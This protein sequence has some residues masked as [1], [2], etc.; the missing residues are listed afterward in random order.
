MVRVVKAALRKKGRGNIRLGNPP[1][2]RRQ[3]SSRRHQETPKPCKSDS[4][5]KPYPSEATLRSI[6]PIWLFGRVP[7]GFWQDETNRRNYLLWLGYKLGFR[8]IEDWYRITH[9]DLKRHNGQGLAGLYWNASAIVG[10][11]ECFPEYDWK[12]WLFK[13]APRAFWHDK[14]NHRRYMTW[15]GQQLGYR[16]PEDWY[17]VATRDFQKHKGGSFL[18]EYHGFVSAVM[19]YLPDYDWKEWMFNQAPSGFWAS[20]KNRHRYMKWLGKRL[21]YKRWED[22]Y[23]VTENDFR[24]NYGYECFK[25]YGGSVIAAVK[26]LYPTRA[27]CEWRFV[28]VP[29]G[30]WH[31]QEN[32][33]RYVR[34]LGEQLG[35]RRLEDWYQV[36]VKD[37]HN[38]SGGAVL[39]QVGCYRDLLKE[40]IPGLDWD[41]GRRGSCQPKPS[42]RIRSRRSRK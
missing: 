17:Q 21:G 41:R 22:W 32:R 18:L 10:V 33:K 37:I 4:H 31:Y 38:N 3:P 27:W 35:V 6:D 26:D 42:R 19:S 9:T 28:R 30:F 7:N 20:Q 40:C 29:A 24:R 25:R 14:A 12:E 8:R 34:W 23:A 15:L 39:E 5:G 13:T 11:K 1:R 2:R 16:R 36:R